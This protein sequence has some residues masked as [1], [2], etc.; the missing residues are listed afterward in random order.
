MKIGDLVNYNLQPDFMF[1][2]DDYGVGLILEEKS[3]DKDGYSVFLVWWPDYSYGSAEF[4]H[5]E[6]D[7][8]LIPKEE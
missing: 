5:E 8:I 2:P 1:G 7:L 6:I 3:K 4:E